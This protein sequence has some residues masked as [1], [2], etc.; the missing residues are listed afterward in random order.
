M[1]MSP[2]RLLSRIDDYLG[3][4]S[5]TRMFFYVGVR[6]LLLTNGD[7]THGYAE[8]AFIKFIKCVSGSS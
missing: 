2:R 6:V 1:M 4:R 7:G 3:P 8:M 5:D